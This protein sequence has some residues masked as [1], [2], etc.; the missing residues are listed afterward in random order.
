MLWS[1]NRWHCHT[2]CSSF[3][4]LPR[5]P[6]P[7][8]SKAF[9]QILGKDRGRRLWSTCVSDG[10]LLM[11]CKGCK[12]SSSSKG[13]GLLQNC[14]GPAAGTFGVTAGLK[15]LKRGLHPWK[16]LA[17]SKP[18]PVH[19]H[20]PLLTPSCEISANSVSHTSTSQETCC[21]ARIG[22]Q[23]KARDSVAGAEVAWSELFHSPVT[24]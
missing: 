18:W 13:V 23:I 1:G 11:Y 4:A 10:T 15:R 22:N 7:G 24:L 6:C 17:I 20:A 9:K 19:I 2:C 8:E 14:S 21:Q 5:H 12:C 16:P 3:Q